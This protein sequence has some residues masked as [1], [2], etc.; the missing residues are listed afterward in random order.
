MVLFDDGDELTWA[1]QAPLWVLP[2]GQGLIVADLLAFV[3]KNRLEEDLD[4]V[5][6]NR[7]LQVVQVVV[8]R[9]VPLFSRVVIVPQEAAAVIA[10]LI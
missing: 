10:D 5:L 9:H 1:D 7:L 8:A 3:V 4:P 6:V 2:A